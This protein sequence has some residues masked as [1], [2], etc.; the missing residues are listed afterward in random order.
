MFFFA[1][2]CV[3]LKT[4][5]HP[6]IVKVHGKMEKIPL[7]DIKWGNALGTSQT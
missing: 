7:S 3:C 1:D 4:V 5:N 6:Q 2:M